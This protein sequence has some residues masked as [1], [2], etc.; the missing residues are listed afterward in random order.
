MCVDP[1]LL[2]VH[3]PASVHSSSLPTPSEASLSVWL[4]QKETVHAQ[5]QLAAKQTLERNVVLCISG[6]REFSQ[7]S[8]H[9]SS[10]VALQNSQKAQL[11]PWGRN[12]KQMPRLAP[13]TSTVG[14]SQSPSGDIALVLLRGSWR[15]ER[16]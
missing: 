11:V 1:P 4:E 7:I 15:P 9:L 13:L 8:G 10:A 3:R 16:S 6:G 14:R 12:C 2:C 5:R